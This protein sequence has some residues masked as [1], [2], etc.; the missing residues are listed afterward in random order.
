MQKHPFTLTIIIAIVAAFLGEFGSR[1]LDIMSGF[2]IH[3]GWCGSQNGACLFLYQL[4][5][6]IGVIVLAFSG[7]SLVLRYTN[8]TKADFNVW[9]PFG[10]DVLGGVVLHNNSWVDLDD[11]I[12]ELIRYEDDEYRKAGIPNFSDFFREQ[13]RLPRKLFWFADNEFET[14]IKIG[15][16]K[17]GFL[18]IAFPMEEKDQ[19]VAGKIMAYRVI[20]DGTSF[21]EPIKEGWFEI[22]MSAQVNN[23]P[24]PLLKIGVRL[25]IENNIPV[26]KE[27]KKIT[28]QNILFW[29]VKHF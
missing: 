15:R 26:I 8:W 22:R 9:H 16:G 25:E 1:G 24:L 28:E 18:A 13:G 17:E 10:V 6:L 19:I 29:K 5:V 21:G 14:A 20:T 4:G 3:L 2:I 27:I 23:A 12:A 11:C 7:D